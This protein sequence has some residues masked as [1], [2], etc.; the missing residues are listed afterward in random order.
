MTQ[1]YNS[2]PF[3]TFIGHFA[4]DSIIRFDE[5]RSP[6]LGGSVSYCSLAL[7]NYTNDVKIGIISNLGETNFDPALLEEIKAKGIDLSGLKWFNTKNTNFVLHY[8]NHSRE[9]TLKSRS[10]D[11]KT[12]DIPESYLSSPPDAIVLVPLCNEISLE[13]VTQIMEKFPN[14]LVGIDL[15]GFIRTI[16]EKGVVSLKRENYLISEINEIIKVIGEKLI[17]KGSEEEMKILSGKEDL[18]EIMEYFNDEKFKGISI[19][20]LG[21][22]GSMITKYGK[23][24]IIIPAFRPDQVADETGAGD[25]YLSIFLYEF[26]TSDKS[27]SSIRNAGLLASAAASFL[28]EEKGPNGFQPKDK[29]L[30][31]LETKDYLSQR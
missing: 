18:T 22:K 25:A 19:M 28:V 2:K 13:Y 12:E 15:Q 21:E 3:F 10:P 8:H 1:N 26:L 4:I 27:W 24:L 5:E 23:Q 20:T 30:K 29:I 17:L 11:L 6:T 7:K 16:D 14:A 9:L 31:R